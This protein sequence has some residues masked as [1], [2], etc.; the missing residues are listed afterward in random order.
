MTATHIALLRGV[1][2]GPA[3]RVAM[4]DLRTL[5]GGLG[6][7][8]PRTLLNSG[9]VLFRVPKGMRGNHASRLEAEIAATVG[10]TCRVTVLTAA[11]LARIIE[12]NPLSDVADNP[13]RLLVSVLAKAAD[14]RKILPL[15]ALDWS[16]EVLGLGG[17]AAY[18]W[19]E[20]G[21]QVSRLAQRIGRVLGDGVTSRNWATMTRLQQLTTG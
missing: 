18:V 16:P 7:L 2:L 17:R 4:A 12:E 14:R 6:Y 1:N 19:C 21:I 5:V 13:S 8:D 3:N 15:A 9:N 11:E 10:V 20:E